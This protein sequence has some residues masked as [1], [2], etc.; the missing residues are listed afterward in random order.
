[1]RLN[2]EIS[3][4]LQQNIKKYVLD[5]NTTIRDFIT[6]LIKEKINT[7][8]VD[9]E[10]KFTVGIVCGGPSSERGIS[11][12][13]A[14]SVADHL[15]NENI[16][17]EVFYI[18]QNLDFY[19]I[20]RD[21]LYSNT[22]SDFDFKLSYNTPLSKVDFVNELKK[23]TIVFP[24]VHGNYG[25]DG[26]L[27]ELLEKN[28]IAFVGSNS[29][30]SK[31]SFSKISSNRLLAESGFYTFPF[32]SFSENSKENKKI[33]E[34]FFDLNNLKKAIVKP[35]NGGSSIG[36]HCVY[37]YQEANEK[38]ELLFKQK[39]SPIVVEPFCGGR[40]FT[41]VLIENLAT[42]KPVALLPTG[43]EMKYQHYEI[44][45]YRKKY[46]PT[47]QT[48]FYTPPNFKDEEIEKIQKYAE[49]IYG[50]MGFRDFI[51][52][53]GWLLND[54]RIW[55]SDIN[56]APGM[57]QNSF[58][59]Q[60]SSRIGLSHK[61]YIRH[62]LETACIR[63]NLKFPRDKTIE[64]ANKKRVNIIFGGANAERQVSL[65]SG[66]NVWL[67]L[68]KST[69]YN[70]IPYLLDKDN[71]VWYLPYYYTLSHT[72]EEIYENCI[73]AKQNQEKMQRFANNICDK[74]G[75]KNCKIELPIK[76]SFDE[77]IKLSK[78][79]NAFVFL[80]L[81]GGKGEDG[82]IQK[83]LTEN[84]IA[85]N[86]SDEYGSGLSMDKY[87]TGTIINELND[88]VLTSAPKIKFKIDDFKN[89]DME[90][91]LKFW[92]DKIIN[93]NSDSFII[94]PAEDG[95]SAGVVRIYDCSEFKTYIDF[96]ENATTQYIP[97]NTFKNQTNIVEMP[98]NIKQY[99]ILEPFIETDNIYVKNNVIEYTPI[100]NWLELTVGIIENNGKYHSF[101]P[102][103]TIAEN[104]IL[105]IEEKFQGGTGINITPPPENIINKEL[106]EIIKNNIE[107]AAKTLKLKNYARIDI[108]VNI[109]TKKIIL[110]EANTLPALTPST[111]IF[112]QAL[113]EDEAMAPGNFLE[114]IIDIKSN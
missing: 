95:S 61:D 98:S 113:K 71:N 69:K 4:F 10:N 75:I 36:V 30:V 44:F 70:P 33:I 3:E 73:N 67:K 47:T 21:Q 94:K 51:R 16:N 114:K 103:I 93:L 109:K 60:Q 106:I 58:V 102:S 15:E 27:Q 50:L 43:I 8:K 7:K 83:Q 49:E 110:I 64:N 40:E 87:K 25:E 80:A 20:D 48:R 82:T 63:Y 104:K 97:A 101:S 107:K 72:V 24:I 46:L 34:R 84:N 11:L 41:I 32:V 77:F 100:T 45:D 5:N 31:K 22:P 90:D 17:I 96:L 28:N 52:M 74:L 19:R 112:H 23:V 111:V 79:E 66:T 37:S 38:V 105:T 78:K 12:N 13:S 99:F 81:H 6:D 88:E 68:L 29:I 89:Y 86:G 39:M 62:V 56:I 55:F 35:A 14:R 57:E 92:K 53:D 65:M 42:K 26:Q 59:F 76:Y 2:I 9:N 18:D 54:G 108:F 1:M 91:Y 85:Y